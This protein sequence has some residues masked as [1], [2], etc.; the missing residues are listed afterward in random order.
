MTDDAIEYAVRRTNDFVLGAASG[1]RR[2]GAA[3]CRRWDGAGPESA[4]VGRASAL[5]RAGEGAEE[6]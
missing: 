1:T 3:R 6:R 4:D 5:S 2:F